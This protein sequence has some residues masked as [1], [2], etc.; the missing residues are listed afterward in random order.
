MFFSLYFVFFL[1][2]RPSEG[3]GFAGDFFLESSGLQTFS[4]CRLQLEA[5]R[6]EE[7][8]ANDPFSA[9]PLSL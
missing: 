4:L 3:R 9:K 6:R 7:P 8:E 1:A 2:N 5:R